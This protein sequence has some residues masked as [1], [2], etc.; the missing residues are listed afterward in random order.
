M[1]AFSIEEIKLLVDHMSQAPVPLEL[2][3]SSGGFSIRIA[4]S[5]HALALEAVHLNARIPG[6]FEA[7][8]VPHDV[9]AGQML[10]V[11]RT[12]DGLRLPVR[13]PVSG[14]VRRAHVAGGDKVARGA[15]LFTL[16]PS[17]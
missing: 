13:S 14:T 11:I 4:T 15:M 7:V 6:I 17:S 10:G 2:Q 3:F 1:A 16:A 9:A 12:R 5:P 8:G